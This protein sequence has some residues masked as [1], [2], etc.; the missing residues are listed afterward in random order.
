MRIKKPIPHSYRL[1]VLKSKKGIS[2]IIAL[3]TM[4]LILSISFS[5]GGII[6]RQFRIINT[7]VSSQTAFY[8][9][10]SA[11]ECATYWDRISDDGAIN[12]DYNSSV[13][14]TTTGSSLF[15][16]IKCGPSS[17]IINPIKTIVNEAVATSTFSINYSGTDYTACAFVTVVKEI[18]RT[19]VYARGYNTNT[20][21]TGCNLT[22][23]VQR[24][25]VE[26]GIQYTQ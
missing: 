19:S 23:A 13:F 10:D 20:T 7:S 14:G 16:L 18:D 3:F 15:D 25:V 6:L 12:M 17:A 5:V 26:R 22:D 1:N 9:A 8:A 21:P 24:R 2:L 4:T 11:I